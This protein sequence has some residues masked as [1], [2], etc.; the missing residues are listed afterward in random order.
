MANYY[1]EFSEVIPC[2]NEIQRRWLEKMLATA[3]RDKGEGHPAC[4]FARQAEGHMWVNSS[5]SGAEDLEALVLVVCGFQLK[6]QI[7]EPWSLTWAETCSSPRVGK[8]SGGAVVVFK[9]K[10]EWLY[11]HSWCDK[12]KAAFRKTNS[13]KGNTEPAYLKS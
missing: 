10:D 13:A 2:E 6:F 1:T 4:E 11:T 9:G 5:D 7:T 12:K 3:V 8:F